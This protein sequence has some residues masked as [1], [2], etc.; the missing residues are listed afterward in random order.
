MEGGLL[1]T[2]IWIDS[3]I[4]I[5]GTKRIDSWY[6]NLSMEHV[7]ISG[8]IWFF[9]LLFFFIASINKVT[10]SNFGREMFIS[11]YRLKSIIEGSQ[12]SNLRQ[13][14]EAEP[15]EECCLLACF[16]KL[17]YSQISYTAQ[18]YLQRGDIIHSWLSSPTSISNQKNMPNSQHSHMPIW[19]RQFAVI[20]FPSQVYQFEYQD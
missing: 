19:W 17:I 20:V 15:T 16:F 9:F 14:L 10:K 6:H 8:L 4:P 5:W 7:S 3:S 12:G 1:S 2:D 11:P 18:D 13:E